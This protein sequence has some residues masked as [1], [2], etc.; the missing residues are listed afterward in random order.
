[1]SQRP[2]A[3]LLIVEDDPKQLRLYA[4]I[5]GDCRLTFAANGT[6]ALAALAEA[7]PDVI[8]LDHVLAD[9]ERGTDFLPRLKTAA[10]HVP[11]IIISGTLDIEGQLSALQGPLAA[12]YV[13]KKPVRLA[14]LEAT[15]EKALSECGVGEAVRVLRSL[16]SAE[17][18][19]ASEPER[20]FT[21]RL[22]RQHELLN[23][24]RNSRER[25][26]I[27]ALSREFNVHRRTIQRDLQDLIQR[28]QLDASVCPDNLE[29]GDDAAAMI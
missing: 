16:E 20:R 24:L 15:V 28:G 19:A 21:E 13:L 9:G 4:K 2:R 1:M 8:V 3:S 12:H 22:S 11:V 23:R 5:F 29:S 14:D 25:A 27:S 10:A 6:A 7:R 26:N 18:I 17:K